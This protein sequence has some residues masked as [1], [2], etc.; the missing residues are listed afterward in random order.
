[1]R[2]QRQKLYPHPILTFYNDD[3]TKGEFTAEL[4]E[5]EL[6]HSKLR[7]HF[8]YALDCPPLEV[9]VE[10]GKA[11]PIIH[12]ENSQTKYRNAFPLTES[13]IDIPSQKLNGQ[14]EVL[15]MIVANQ[16]F[17][18]Y[19]NNYLSDD[20]Q[21][22]SFNIEE[23]NILAIQQD[24][25]FHVEKEQQDDANIPSIFELVK[26][27]EQ[28]EAITFDLYTSD[29]III[30]T[31]HD[32]QKYYSTLEDK[33]NPRKLLTSLVIF[34]ALV[35]AINN[36]KSEDEEIHQDLEE[37]RWYNSIKK[38]LKDVDINP[39]EQSFFDKPSEAI[40]QILLRNV[41]NEAFHSLNE[42]TQ[43]AKESE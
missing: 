17:E 40:A 18:Y 27:D 9:L 24:A 31:N 39:E 29:K 20:Y 34:P 16:S 43:H 25:T 15:P 33:E 3:Y 38:R 8:N 42:L 1:M 6:L 22:M 30:N 32:V 37:K 5:V 11:T 21:G 28:K 4:V 23:G 35:Q 41:V 10:N 36:M 26:N 19:Y 12:I 13:Y 2:L 14:V 7:L